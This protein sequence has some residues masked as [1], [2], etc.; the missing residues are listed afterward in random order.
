MIE[1]IN[2]MVKDFI[3]KLRLNDRIL[4]LA[5]VDFFAVGKIDHL[6]K[7]NFRNSTQLL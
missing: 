2:A 1:Y 5:T 7:T 4:E 6:R 3:T